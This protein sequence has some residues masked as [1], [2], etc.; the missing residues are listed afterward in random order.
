MVV[1]T[2]SIGG[3][4]YTRHCNL[5]QGGYTFAWSRAPNAGENKNDF[6]KIKKRRKELKQ[7]LL[8][9][10][11]PPLNEGMSGECLHLCTFAMVADCVPVW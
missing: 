8:Q 9:G 1:T 6:K 7:L 3:G 2:P 10:S 4:E 11:V 5:V